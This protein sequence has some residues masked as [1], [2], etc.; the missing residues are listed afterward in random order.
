MHVPAQGFSPY[1][2]QGLPADQ[3]QSNFAALEQPFLFEG[4]YGRR[5]LLQLQVPPS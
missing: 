1:E 2:E 5:H 3:E 4:Q